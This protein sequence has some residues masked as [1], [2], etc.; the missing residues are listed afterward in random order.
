[1]NSAT[2]ADIRDIRMAPRVAASFARIFAHSG[3][4]TAQLLKGVSAVRYSTLRGARIRADVCAMLVWRQA[5]FRL[6]R[7]ALESSLHFYGYIDGSPQ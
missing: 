5:L 4:F 6:M 2:L 3:A 7:T 1:M